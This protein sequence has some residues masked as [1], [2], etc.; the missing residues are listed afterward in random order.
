V[1]ERGH[2]VLVGFHNLAAVLFDAAE[3][4]IQRGIGDAFDAG[5][6]E[7]EKWSRLRSRS[8]ESPC[9]GARIS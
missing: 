5:L 1:E 8:G 2:G 3:I 7:F 4:E 9:F 6:G